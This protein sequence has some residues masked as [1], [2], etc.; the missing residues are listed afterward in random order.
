MTGYNPFPPDPDAVDAYKDRTMGMGHGV[1]RD[2]EAQARTDA[3]R[4]AIEVLG[5]SRATGDHGRFVSDET[6]ATYAN[7]FANFILNGEMQP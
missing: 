6:L 5:Y 1:R 2:R 4:I 3:L 7:K